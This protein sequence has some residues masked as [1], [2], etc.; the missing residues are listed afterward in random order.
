MKRLLTTAA[1]GVALTACVPTETD[2]QVQWTDQGF[3][4]VTLGGQVPSHTLSAETTPEIYG[5]AASITSTQDVGGGF[6]FEVAGGYKVWRNLAVGVGISHVGSKRDLAITGSIPD[7]LVT[8]AHRNVT[9]TVP[10]AKHGQTAINLTGTWMMPFTDKVD[11]G[12]HFGPTIF[13]VSQDLP[14]GFTIQEPTPTITSTSLEKES[15]TSVGIHFGVDATYLITPR[16]GVGALLRY[17][18]GSVDF[19]GAEDSLTVGGLHLGVGLRV[20]F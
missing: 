17:T 18:W 1:L 3:V 20:R 13:R 2:A 9:A 5:E 7:P 14:S 15:K 19:G 12:F 4:N 6:L 16:Y 11:F 10:D 8:D